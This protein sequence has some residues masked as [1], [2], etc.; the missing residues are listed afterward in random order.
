MEIEESQPHP[1]HTL[2]LNLLVKGAQNSHGLKRGDYQQY[3][4]YCA[5][6]VR[7]MRKQMKFSLAIKDKFVNRKVEQERTE[8]PRSLQ[9]L[10]FN[11][12]KNWAHANEVKDMSKNRKISKG[13]KNRQTILKKFKKALSWAQRLEEVCVAHADK[14]ATFEAETYRLFLEG[15]VSFET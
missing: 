1:V 7:K 6:K 13:N 11:A 14:K 8:D 2:S 3:R 4:L 5:N 12:E 10:L 15:M 9:V